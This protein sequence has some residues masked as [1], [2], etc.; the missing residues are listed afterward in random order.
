MCRLVKSGLNKDP[1]SGDV[2]ILVGRW[3]ALKKFLDRN[4]FPPNH[5][6]LE[7]GTAELPPGK[8]TSTQLT[9]V[10]E[11]WPRSL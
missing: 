6:R 7:E 1:L 5:K 10:L 11:G 9:M 8:P 3:K 4:G 2:C